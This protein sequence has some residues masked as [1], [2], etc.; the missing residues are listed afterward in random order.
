MKR[1]LVNP[2]NNWLITGVSAPEST[3]GTALEEFK[4]VRSLTILGKG[5][6]MPHGLLSTHGWLK[7]VVRLGIGSE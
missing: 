5:K 6:G 7:R 2:Q 4:E 1:I 3:A